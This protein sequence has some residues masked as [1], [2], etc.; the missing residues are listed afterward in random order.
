KTASATEIPIDGVVTY[1]I[2]ITNNSAFDLTNVHVADPLPSGLL[3]MGTVP[4]QDTD[5][6]WI[7]ASLGAGETASFQIEAM[8]V[9]K[10]EKVNTATISVGEFTDQVTAPTVTV[11]AKQVDISVSKTSFG[12]AIYEGNEFEY[13]I[14]LTNNGLSSA[15]D[16][17][18]S[19]Q[20]PTNVEFISFTGTDPGATVSGNTISW[21]VS[22]IAAGE[23]LVYVIKVQAVGIGAV[24]NTV[25]IEVPDNQDNISTNKE[26]SDTNQIIRFFVPNVI[27]PGN[28]DGKND[29]FEIKG[30]ENFAKSSLTI[31]NR[32][33][34]HVF[35]SENYMNDWA[36]EGL[37]PGAYFYVLIITDNS[38]EEQTYKGWVQVIK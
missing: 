19:D 4:A 7:I 26:D 13:E 25:N 24:T 8:G 15:E 28:L 37:N 11:V 1:T 12:K 9:E 22:S 14:K 16:V 17:V 34:D 21:T 18:V 3:N 30:I 35:E 38:G 32:N 6:N 23:D 29:T 10:G 36:A 5:G 20:L 31:L 33:G 2:G 27:T